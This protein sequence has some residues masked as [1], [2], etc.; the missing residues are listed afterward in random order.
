M[1]NHE[2]DQIPGIKDCAADF[3]VGMGAT[4]F[5]NFKIY[6]L[7]DHDYFSSVIDTWRVGITQRVT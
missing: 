2:A 7:C 3:R 1:P 5:T 4:L 6:Y